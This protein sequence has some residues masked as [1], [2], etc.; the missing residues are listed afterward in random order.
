MLSGSEG[1]GS[2]SPEIQNSVKGRLPHCGQETLRAKREPN[3]KHWAFS[4]VSIVVMSNKFYEFKE[5]SRLHPSIPFVTVER[6][7]LFSSGGGVLR[8]G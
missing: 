6:V 3:S 7:C 5:L 8:E 4:F 2:T 1:T